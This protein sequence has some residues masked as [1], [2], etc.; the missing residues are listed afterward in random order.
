MKFYLIDFNQLVDIKTEL[1]IFRQSL[2]EDDRLK[3]LLDLLEN[4]FNFQEIGETDQ[5]LSDNIIDL[6]NLWASWIGKTQGG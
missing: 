2:G 3:H 4:I 5:L 1:A 6:R